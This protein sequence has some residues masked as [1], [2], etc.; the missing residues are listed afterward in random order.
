MRLIL[1][2]LLV[3]ACTDPSA[4]SGKGAG[5]TDSAQSGDAAHS[6]DSADTA[7]SAD[8]ADAIDTAESADTGLGPPEPRTCSPLT[9]SLHQE[10][11]G[12]M[13][14][15]TREAA[16]LALGGP[17]LAAG[18]F[19]GDGHTDA[20]LARPT[21]AA[22]LLVGDGAGGLAVSPVEL[23]QGD[24]ATAGDFDQDGALDVVLAGVGTD[25]WLRG[26]GD[27]TFEVRPLPQADR[28]TTT[29]SAFDADG[30][31]D[32][33]LYAA[34]HAWPVDFEVLA[35][36]DWD[37]DGSNLLLNDA[38]FFVPD[39]R[40]LGPS[41]QSL[42]FVGA[43]VDVDQ[44][45][46]L[47]IYLN[48]D[49]GTWAGPSLVLEN[50]GTGRL[51]DRTGDGAERAIYAM[52]TA[53]GD[54]TGNGWP[55]LVLSDIGA[56]D[57]LQALGDSTYAEA[58]AAF[59]L[60]TLVAADRTAS[61]GSR[62][63][64]LDGDGYDDLAFGF[65]AVPNHL[66]GGPPVGTED[67]LDDSTHQRDAVLRFDPEARRFVDWE[68][69]TGDV[70][71]LADHHGTKALVTADLDQDGRPE[72]ITAGYTPSYRDLAV[73]VWQVEGGC[74]PGA[75]L[76]FPP[77]GRSVGARVTGTVGGQQITRWMLPAATYGSSAFEV[78]VGLGEVDRVEDL[79]VTWADG[80]V[81]PLGPVWAGTVVT[82][83]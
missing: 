29:V 49:F 14:T 38:G 36:G 3:C 6:G 80:R 12:L 65:S 70:S 63:V 17:G 43:P 81:E 45:G 35:A 39:P 34:R 82:L 54:W 64:D 69:L 71:A 9:I 79:T 78:F 15:T 4:P 41:H 68:T 16:R 26:V 1:C 20:V 67:G 21:Q 32:L 5:A 23:P 60:N 11:T 27:G 66:S 61:W 53:V 75:T 58:G 59:G 37:G 52:G 48:T 44:D 50:D 33:D 2:T 72:L 13:G 62:A 83:E 19:T 55:D 57:L 47:D 7:E 40:L 8:T 51:T 24:T 46:D 25:V 31:G 77:V 76:R 10:L 18:D 28:H 30:D 22:L 73:N 56:P 42:G 74:G